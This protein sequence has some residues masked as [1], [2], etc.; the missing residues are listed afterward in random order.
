[1]IGSFAKGW[2]NNVKNAF[3]AKNKVHAVVFIDSLYEDMQQ[4]LLDCF[5]LWCRTYL[6]LSSLSFMCLL[7]ELKSPLLGNNYF[8]QK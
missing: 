6:F 8:Q 7:S 1:M 3:M 5:Y 4:Q 2:L